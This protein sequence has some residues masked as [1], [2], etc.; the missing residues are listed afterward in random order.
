MQ[1]LNIYPWFDILY[2]F[3]KFMLSTVTYRVILVHFQ[4]IWLP[5]TLNRLLLVLI[6]STKARRFSGVAFTVLAHLEMVASRNDGSTVSRRQPCDINNLGVF[7]K[8][9]S[10]RQILYLEAIRYPMVSF[11][12]ILHLYMGNTQ[13]SIQQF[14]ANYPYLP[15]RRRGFGP[16]MAAIQNILP[17]FGASWNRLEP[18]KCE[19]W[20]KICYNIWRDSIG[21]MKVTCTVEPFNI[22]ATSK[23]EMTR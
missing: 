22:R 17:E 18:S 16:Q 3:Y 21:S 20:R 7:Q 14:S 15:K 23:E 9:F 13:S 5:S 1:L 19:M 11:A 10:Y 2:K 6:N 12:Y 8:R 4:P